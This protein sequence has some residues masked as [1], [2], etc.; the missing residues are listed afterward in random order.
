MTPRLTDGKQDCRRLQR[1]LVAAERGEIRVR[2]CRGRFQVSGC[3]CEI[4]LK[5]PLHAGHF[6][7]AAA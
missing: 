7:T 3:H 4:D 2:L 6:K 1:L 5:K